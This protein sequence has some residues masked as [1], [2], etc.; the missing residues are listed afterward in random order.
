MIEKKDKKIL[1]HFEDLSFLSSES[2]EAHI[3]Y[4][5]LQALTAKKPREKAKPFTPPTYEEID[6]FIKE[7]GYQVD[8]KAFWGHYQANGW[9]IGKNKMKDWKACIAQWEA[10][11]KKEPK[12]VEKA[13][14]GFP[15]GFD[16]S[17]QCNPAET[18]E[19]CRIR[20]WRDFERK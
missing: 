2:A 14:T 3:L 18:H 7:K 15:P 20:A 16:P 1:V 19:A 5:I 4:E 8:S 6:Q 11:D 17:R 9:M 10:R 12:K 13:R